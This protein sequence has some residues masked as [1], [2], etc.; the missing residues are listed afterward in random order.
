M[1][2]DADSAESGRDGGRVDPPDDRSIPVTILQG[3]S[4]AK[5]VPGGQQADFGNEA[6]VSGLSI[7]EN[8]SGSRDRRNLK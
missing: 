7:S 5:A 8:R 2:C 3:A 4:K 1:V 6:D